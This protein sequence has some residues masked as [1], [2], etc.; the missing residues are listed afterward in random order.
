MQKNK[1]D[2]EKVEYLEKRIIEMMR[3]LNSE[4]KNRIYNITYM[5]YIRSK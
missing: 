1:M 5:M 2:N 4:E 3:G